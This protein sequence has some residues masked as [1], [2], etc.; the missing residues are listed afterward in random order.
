MLNDFAV[1]IIT[2]G[3]P[4]KQITYNMLRAKGYTGKIY[5]VVDNLDNTLDEYKRLYDGEVLVFNKLEYVAKTD[6]ALGEKFI[7]FAVF[8]RN[9]VEDFVKQLNLKTFLLIDDDF[10]NVR[11]RL[12]RE[13]KLLSRQIENFDYVFSCIS[14]Y[15]LSANISTAGVNQSFF[16]GV[17]G[18]NVASLRHR[19][20][21]GMFFRNAGHI[22]EWKS[23]MLEDIIT[24]VLCGNMGE[25][26]IKLMQFQFDTEPTGGENSVGGNASV[27]NSYDHFKQ[28]FFPIVFCPSCFILDDRAMSHLDT[29]GKC[30][31][32]LYEHTVPRLISS[33][34]KRPN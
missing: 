3:R 16:G 13:E 24:C 9:A 29:T 11:M 33:S 34:Y 31:T 15:L 25:P 14:E 28:M 12:V 21:N 5:L 27:Y 22:V 19:L 10:S 8:S 6:C 20:F 4:Y 18:L 30:A 17:K 7:N 23:N 32:I 2:H 1:F 26:F